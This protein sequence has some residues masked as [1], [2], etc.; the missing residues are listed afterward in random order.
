M[1]LQ[2]LVDYYDRRNRHPDP[3]HH[4]PAFGFEDKEI[5]FVIE[6]LPDG[7]VNQLAVERY[8]EGKKTRAKSFLVPMGVKKT[9]GL[10]A[11]LLWDSANYVL[12]LDPSRTDA[13]G[14]T[15]GHLF[16]QR[17]LD[18]PEDTRQDPGVQAVLQ[19][20]DRADWSVLQSHPAWAEIVEKKPVMSF[21]LA[22]DLGLVCERPLVKAAVA[23]SAA[24][25]EAP[26][27]GGVPQDQGQA[28]SPLMHCLVDGTPQP[29]QQLHA[30]IKGVWGAQSSG[31]NIVSFNLRAFESYGK[32][33]RQGENA[34]VGETA[35]FKYTTALN[36]LLQ[37]DSPNR[38]QVGDTST[39]CWT[40]RAD[41]REAL[42]PALFGESPSDDPDRHAASVQ[43]LYDSPHRGTVPVGSD[44]DETI[45]FY[46]LGL[47]PN[48][49]RISIRFWLCEPWSALAPRLRQHFDDLRIVRAYDSDPLTPSLFRL[50]TSI[51]VQGKLENVPPLLAGDWM[52]AI[53]EGRPYPALLL[54][55]AVQRSKAEQ[56]VSYLRAAILKAWLNRDMRRQHPQL[57][58]D[59]A[60]FKETLD[61]QQTDTAYR[62]G[63]LFAVLENLQE[64]AQK[65]I[66]ATILDR[67]YGAASTSPV[68]VFPTLLKLKNA[69]LKKLSDKPGL[70]AHFQHLIGDILG[71]LDAPQV[72]SFPSQLPLP[73]QG[74]FALGYYH[75]RQSL[76][77]RRDGGSGHG[78]PQHD[79]NNNTATDPSH[80]SDHVTTETL[81]S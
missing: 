5:P 36:H 40:D 50:L 45:R 62:L 28:T 44:I 18:L 22:G 26:D 16:R 69:H 60:H 53:L 43:L 71:D 72:I 79:D 48:A 68:T 80:P 19:A 31:A 23:A 56:S 34:P 66:N 15:A 42:L 7:C 8:Q 6:L 49:S 39:V 11:N 27:D 30:S 2:A 58:P 61:M 59:H 74:K 55:L 21:R 51:A 75:Q 73:E 10:K 24:A 78:S 4:L 35:A 14:R 13:D 17:I 25:H 70:V 52:R 57:P 46:V 76:Y 32:A 29:I 77:K 54:N 1:I 81:H 37:R 64:S 41:P 20:L 47:A 33:E 12:D 65:G 3:A 9:S 67:Y 38:M 63:R